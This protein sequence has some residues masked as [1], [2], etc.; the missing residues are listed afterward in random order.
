[1][2]G[3]LPRGERPFLPLGE[4]RERRAAR[5]GINRF[6]TAQRFIGVR[7]IRDRIADVDERIR[8][9]TVGADRDRNPRFDERLDETRFREWTL[10]RRILDNDESRVADERQLL[11]RDAVAVLD[12]RTALLPISAAGSLERVEDDV[13]GAVAADVKQ[14]LLVERGRFL[15]HVPDLRGAEIE[16]SVL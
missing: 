5:V 10:V 8:R 13:V 6:L 15:E 11:G 7:G 2:I 14:D 16:P 3:E 1:E 9:R 4:L 12:A